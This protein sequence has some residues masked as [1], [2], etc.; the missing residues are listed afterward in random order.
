MSESIP[1]DALRSETKKWHR[2]KQA[3]GVASKLFD[4]STE[5]IGLQA[6][7]GRHD[8]NS[9]T[10]AIR[11]SEA[12]MGGSTSSSRSAKPARLNNNAARNLTA[13]SGQVANSPSRD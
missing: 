7:Q 5:L 6:G 12:A 8:A 13:L 10:Q 9:Q 11:S 2:R 3:N 4:I 1:G